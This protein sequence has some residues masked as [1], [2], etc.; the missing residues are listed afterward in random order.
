VVSRKDGVSRSLLY[1]TCDKSH[2]SNAHWRLYSGAW[3]ILEISL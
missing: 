1:D 2:L 3:K